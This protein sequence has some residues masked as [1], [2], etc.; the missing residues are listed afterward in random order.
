VTD[1]GPGKSVISPLLPDVTD[2]DAAPFWW[3]TLEGRLVVQECEQCQT[4]RF[5]PR[6]YCSC[7]S[8]ASRWREMSGRARIWSWCISF[9]PTLRAFAERTPLAIVV[10]ELAEDRSIRMIGNALNAAGAP[11]TE[12]TDLT[13]GVDVQ[14]TMVAAATGVSLPY[15]RLVGGAL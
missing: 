7:L 1:V 13:V 14:V 15:W 9:G 5:P 4:L 12:S 6:P 11:I 8:D 2:E 10:V 3:A